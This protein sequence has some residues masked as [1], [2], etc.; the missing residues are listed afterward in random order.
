MITV[1]DRTCTEVLDNLI[2]DRIKDFTIADYNKSVKDGKYIFDK[3]S[4]Y[5]ITN[6]LP[7]VGDSNVCLN[8]HIMNPAGEYLYLK[9]GNIISN[10]SQM[11]E[12]YFSSYFERVGLHK[13]SLYFTVAQKPESN[14]IYAKRSVIIPESREMA[15][16]F[17]N[18]GHFST[19]DFFDLVKYGEKEMNKRS[20]EIFDTLLENDIVGYDP[21]FDLTK[22]NMFPEN[23]ETQKNQTLY[24]FYNGLDEILGKS[25]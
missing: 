17:P 15:A 6:F 7:S 23:F 12:C 2:D 10:L 16:I 18:M 19:G 9:C 13:D 22:E 8:F 14:L 21:Y 25:R 1:D 4:E 3:D 5:Y 24:E 11:M 20:E